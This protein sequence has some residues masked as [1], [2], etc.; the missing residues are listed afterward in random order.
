MQKRRVEWRGVEV[1]VVGE[2]G[3]VEEGEGRGSRV[4]E[5]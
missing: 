1:E 5:S 2:K 3:E 4:E